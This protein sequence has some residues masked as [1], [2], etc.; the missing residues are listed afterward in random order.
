MI[1]NNQKHNITLQYKTHLKNNIHT[2][3]R[4]HIMKINHNITQPKI[5]ITYLSTKY[6]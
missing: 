2:H 5:H 3:V 6:N 1:N 4:K